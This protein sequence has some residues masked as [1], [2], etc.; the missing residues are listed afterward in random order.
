MTEYKVST[1]AASDLENLYL[2]G[3]ELFGELQADRYRAELDVCFARIARHPQM[4][5]PADSIRFGV[6]RHEHKS[7][8][9]LYKEQPDHVLILAVLH[10]RSVLKLNS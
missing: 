10:G 5:R 1:R 3:I 7:H 8:V 6:R 4:G 9:I 2:D